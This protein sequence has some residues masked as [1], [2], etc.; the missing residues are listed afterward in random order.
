MAGFIDRHARIYVV[1]QNRDGQMLQLMRLDLSPEHIAKEGK[2][3]ALG[4][5]PPLEDYN[6]VVGCH[7]LVDPAFAPPGKHVAQNEMQGPRASDLP[8]KEWLALKEKYAE[9]MVYANLLYLKRAMFE[10]DEQ[11]RAFSQ[12]Q[13]FDLRRAAGKILMERKKTGEKEKEGS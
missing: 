9:A 5:L 11:G 1:E 7:S 6:P 12:F 10:T 4:M 13:A 3:A 8:E 2:W